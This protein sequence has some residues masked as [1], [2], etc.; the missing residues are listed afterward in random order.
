MGVVNANNKKSRESMDLSQRYMAK[1]LDVHYTTFNGWETERDI[2][3][4]ERLISYANRFEFSLDY[5]FGISIKNEKYE[6]IHINQQL[7]GQ[8]LK[9]LRKKYNYTQQEIANKLNTTQSTYSAYE[10]GKNLIPTIY[11]YG[12]INIYENLSIDELLGRKKVKK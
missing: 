4:L 3:P 2:I 9:S 11:L 12:L 1:E 5:L 7:I 6:S 8:N 10:S